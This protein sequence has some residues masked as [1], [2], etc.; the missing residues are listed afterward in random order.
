MAFGVVHS[1]SGPTLPVLADFARTRC[2]YGFQTLG[3]AISKRRATVPR[4]IA[5]QFTEN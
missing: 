3:S 5:V 1:K 2:E 4:A